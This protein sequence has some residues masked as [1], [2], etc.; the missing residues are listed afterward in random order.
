MSVFL[1][2]LLL[3]KFGLLWEMSRHFKSHPPPPSPVPL[4]CSLSHLIQH[5]KELSWLQGREGGPK[6]GGTEG[7][8]TK[9]LKQKTIDSAVFSDQLD[10]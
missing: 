8:K 7:K 3:G 2:V 10:I 5:L 4:L 9:L 6:D 1:L